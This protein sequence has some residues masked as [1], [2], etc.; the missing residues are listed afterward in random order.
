MSRLLCRLAGVLLA[1]GLAVL[2]AVPA[3]ADPADGDL[4]LRGGPSHN[5]GRLEIFHDNEWGTVCD[6]FFGRRDAKVACKQMGYTGAEA[7]L[8]DVA[9]APGRR[10]WLDDVNCVG[11]EA[12]LTE[13]FYNSDVRNS[14]SRT[15]PQWGIANCIPAEQVGV[16]CTASTETNSVE[17]NKSHLTVQEQGGG[18][19]YTVRLGRAPTG[20]VTVAISGQ[21]STVT[22]GSTPLTFTTGNWSTPQTVTLTAFNDSNRTDDSFTLTHTAS[23]GGYGSVTASLSVTVEDDDAPVQAH[24]DSGGIVSLTEGGS[25][26]YRIWLASAPTEQVTVAVTAPSKVSVTPTSLTFTAGNWSTAQTATLEASHDNDTS[27]ETQYVTHRATK[28]GYTTTLSRVQVEITDDDDGEDQIGSRPSGALWWAALTA[29]WETGGATGHIDYTSPHADTGKLSNDSFTYGG[30][31]RAID[32]LFV[33][34]NGHFQIWVDSGNGSVLPNGSVLHVGSVSLTLGS[35]TRQSFRTMYNDGKTPIMREHAYWWQSGSHGVSLSDRQV[36]AVWL[37]VPAGS[38]LPGVP[39]SVNAQA[40]DG[41]ASL[42]W[43]APPEVPSKPVTSYEYQQEGT[44]EW[45][46][47]GGTAT[48]KEVTGLANGESYTFRVRAV[49]AAGKG[50]ASAPSPEVTPAIPGLTGS[51]TSVPASHDGS[52][53]FALQLAFSE[54]VAGRFR[55]MRNDIFEV[56]GGAVTDLRR[57]DRRRDLWTVTVAP[58]SN[59]AVTAAVPAG[60]ACVVSGA[61][62]TSDGHMLTTAISTRIQGP[63]GLTV[64]DAQVQEG[65]NAVLAF[66]VT[67]DPAPSG[68]VTVDYATAD[69]TATAGS[70]YTAASGTLTFAAGE[71]GKTVSVPVLDDA[72]DEGSE[73]LTLTLSNPSGAHVV[74]GSATG[75]INNSDP[76]PGAW[77]VRFGRTVG[78]HVVDALGQRLE[79]S[80]ASHVTVGGLRLTG[81]PG[82]VPEAEPDDPFGLPGWAKRTQ[83][84]E[85]P[86]SLSANDVLLGSAFH[87]SSQR[88]QGAGAAYSAWGRIAISG[89]EAEV[90]DV[91]MDGDVTTG[92]IGFDAE[93]ERVLAGVMLSQSTGE[94]DYRLSVEKGGKAGS[95]DSSLTGVYPY[96]RLVL[97]AR[98][99]A[100]A[101]AGAG[102]G[103]LTLKQEGDEP[104]PT[105]IT[106]RMGAVGFKG[107]VLGEPGE[108]TLALNVKSDA[109]WV[110]TKSERTSDMDATEGDVTRLRLTLEGERA[111]AV[112]EGATFTPSAEVGLRHDGGDAET[113]TGLE[114]GVG[115]SYVAGPLTVEVQVRTLVAHEESGYEE[116]GAS[117]AI[118]ITPDP[119]GQGLTLNIA[120]EWGRTASATERLWSARDAGAL[121]ADRVFEGDARLAVDAGYGV[122]LAHGHGVLTPYAG[123]TLGD[124]GSRAVRTGARWQVGPDAVLGL[125]DT[126]QTNDAGEVDNLVILRLALRF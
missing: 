53:A 8:T 28:G 126:R 58:S 112:G 80:A 61:V 82:A 108:D 59:A 14:S 41:K 50:A 94:G 54:D 29:R 106:M 122:G 110:G 71:T 117:G 89:F 116:W 44:Q 123:L 119:S 99:S 90:D 47:T 38:E 121:G 115:S 120:P 12:K 39:R 30:V 37:E 20:N 23:G 100:W 35:A 21:S 46:S 33:D 16:R 24:I 79:G 113:G 64:A 114:V 72:H 1:A 92:L 9:V 5:E 27:D 49:N 40:R 31:T 102:S 4:R 52:T 76:M 67:L 45:T 93:W 6:D 111:F 75:T 83:P 55:R 109:M 118:R 70:D 22:V 62:C 2:S 125:E 84:E 74:D 17:F 91:T 3:H 65:P 10:F 19:T 86:Q 18:S 105:D 25:R 68:T 69:G 15:S 88:G 51:F 95:V 87:L 124:A 7:Y 78:S 32:G 13:C 57:V 43:G 85:S 103:E 60:R 36:V 104:M 98:M 34:R 101:L 42:E 73:T 11:N 96:A 56:T 26:T 77:M 66:A 107:R 97:N 48:T 63:P 81:A